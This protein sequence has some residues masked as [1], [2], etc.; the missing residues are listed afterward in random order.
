MDV[1]FTF[2]D[3]ISCFRDN[4]IQTDCTAFYVLVSIA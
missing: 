3:R 1:F 4:E 2:W